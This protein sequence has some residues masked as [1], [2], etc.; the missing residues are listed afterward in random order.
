M[1]ET[2]DKQI[3]K[4]EKCLTKLAAAKAEL[5]ARQQAAAPP[6]LEYV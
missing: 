1:D 5:E 2:P 3:M 6:K 4:I